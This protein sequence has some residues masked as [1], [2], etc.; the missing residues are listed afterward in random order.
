MK[1]SVIV[2]S[3]NQKKYLVQAL[4]SVLDQTF[5]PH[6]IIVCDDFSRDGSQE[7]IQS[8]QVRFPDLI[9][10]V[11]QKKNLGV[12]KNRNIG[13]KMAKGD[14]ITTLDGDDLYL[15]EKLGKEAEKSIKEG[16]DLVYSNLLYM[17]ENGDKTG[18]R[19][20]NN[21]MAEGCLFE[22]IATLKLPAPREVFIARSC[23]EQMGFQDESLSINED[24]EW[25]VRFASQFSFVAVKEPLVMHRIHSKGLS[26][27]NRLLLLETQK[28]VVEKMIRLVDK[29]IVKDKQ[30]TFQKLSAFLNLTRAR[31]AA[32]KNNTCQA[33]E[34]LFKAVCQDLFRS[35]NY[36][37]YMRLLLP[38]FFKRQ[39]RLPDSLMIG[40]LAL[41][42]YIARGVL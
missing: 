37:L 23:I 26:Q 21:K 6:E 36:D 11:F 4:H 9:K 14:F 41:P 24:F 28:Q 38:G 22:R 13:I 34:F 10:P 2:T 32:Y 8:F 17:D 25:I 15:P 20:K 42:F 3:Y 31:I 12:T 18:I 16:A 7:I 19:Y 5:R 40:P 29:S 1:I 27:S 33:K 30:Q 39:A 35:A